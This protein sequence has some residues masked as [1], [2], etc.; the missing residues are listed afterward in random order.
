MLPILD[1]HFGYVLG[2]V[3]AHF[4]TGLGSGALVAFAEDRQVPR[5]FS[6]QGALV[7][8]LVH[9]HS[10]LCSPSLFPSVPLGPT[11]C[12]WDFETV[13]EPLDSHSGLST[14]GGELSPVSKERRVK[15]GR[16]AEAG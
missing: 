12:P 9:V 16:A 14:S 4:V 8:A 2:T 13:Q 3:L 11:L 1:H 15:A 6:Q 7:Q 10:V 5:Q